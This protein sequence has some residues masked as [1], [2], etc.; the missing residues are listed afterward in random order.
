MPQND[1]VAL[2]ESIAIIPFHKSIDSNLEYN[3]V[4]ANGP[5]TRIVNCL[6]SQITNEIKIKDIRESQLTDEIY[7]GDVAVFLLVDIFKIDF[8]DFIDFLPDFYKQAWEENGIFVYHEYMTLDDAR[9]NVKTFF[10]DYY[11]SYEKLPL[12]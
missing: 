1:C 6:I 7:L 11:V 3:K 5:K 8:I 12:E 4:I 2:I 9:A 10:Y